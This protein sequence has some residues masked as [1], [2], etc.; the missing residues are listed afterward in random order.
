MEV[1]ELLRELHAL[2]A[3]PPLE[4]PESLGV[5]EERP[6]PRPVVR[7]GAGPRRLVAT[8]QGHRHRQFRLRRRHRRRRRR[9]AR[10]V[11][12]GASANRS[13]RRRRRARRTR[14]ALRARVP[15][16]IRLPPVAEHAAHRSRTHAARDR[17]ARRTR[18]G[19]SRPTRGS[20]R[21]AGDLEVEVASGIDW[22]ELRGGAVFGNTRASLPELLAALRQGRSSITLSRTARS[23]SCLTSWSERLRALSGVGE[24]G[25]RRRAVHA[26][27][28]RVCS[29]RC[30]PQCRPREWT[31]RSST[32]AA[33]CNSFETLQPADPPP[34]FNGELRHVSARRARVAALPPAL[35]L[36]RLPRRRHGTRQD[37]PGARA[38]RGAATREGGSVARR[39]AALAA[40]QLASGGDAVH[41]R[42]ARARCTRGA[43]A[44]AT[45]RRSRTTTSCSSRTARCAATRPCSPSRVRLRDPRRGAGDQERRRQRRRRPRGC[46]RAKHRLAMSG[47]PV[48]NRIAD[49]WS[50]FEF[51]NPG[52]L[53]A[54][55][56]LQGVRHRR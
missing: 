4:L 52:M 46:S 24:D 2:P 40:V 25:R 27:A 14:A 47:T 17:V 42:D 23:A 54:A 16:G 56:V 9:A 38:A 37:R 7:L 28:G 49:L 35:R 5:R 10:D 34:S 20:V 32:R 3:V 50:L 26:L 33:S 22:F 29:M 51:L 43:S 31:R 53:G 45:P 55:R 39:R 21:A 19:S 18:A 15:R 41:A 8:C 6:A 48:E 1:D 30:S 44:R 13:P 36:R 12:R 11:R